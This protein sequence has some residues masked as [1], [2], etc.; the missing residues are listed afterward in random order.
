MYCKVPMGPTSTQ[1]Y[2]HM[3]RYARWRQ[4]FAKRHRSTK[5]KHNQKL[6]QGADWIRSR[7]SLPSQWCRGVNYEGVL[8]FDESHKA[9][10]L[11]VSLDKNK[12]SKA[13]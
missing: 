12:G 10:N 6:F 3:G 1:P 9:K 7:F 11:D 13:C 4:R 8:V 5:T 2:S